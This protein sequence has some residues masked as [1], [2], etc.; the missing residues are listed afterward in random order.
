LGQLLRLLIIF[1]AIWLVVQLVRRA[2]SGSG[3]SR[4]VSR[5]TPPRMLACS[6]C[7]VHV[8]EDQAIVRSGK[9]YCCKEHEAAG[10]RKR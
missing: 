5:S 3:Q 4:R 7:G 6:Y 9:T 8:P 2:L 10:G 1:A